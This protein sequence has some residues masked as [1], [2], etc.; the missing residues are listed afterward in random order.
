MQYNG[1]TMSDGTEFRVLLEFDELVKT[2]EEALHAGGLVTLPMGISKPGSPR[3]I[4]PQQVVS[5]TNYMAG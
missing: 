2:L 3:V 4:N 1:M 5:L